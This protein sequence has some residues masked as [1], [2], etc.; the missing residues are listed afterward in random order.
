MFNK[1]ISKKKIKKL[2]L[3]KVKKSFGGQNHSAET[4]KRTSK[5]LTLLKIKLGKNCDTAFF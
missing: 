2:H 5:V 4:T 3:V 1:Q